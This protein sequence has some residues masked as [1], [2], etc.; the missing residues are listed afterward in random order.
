M[1][2]QPASGR[3]QESG[4]AVTA[5]IS[6]V[7]VVN[8]RALRA[9]DALA[10]EVGLTSARWQVLGV[11]AHGPSTVADIAREREL[12]RQSVQRTVER[13]R[14]E[15]LVRTEPNPDDRRAPLISLTPQAS[16]ALRALAPKQA[17]WANDLAAEL[18]LEE[19]R[20]ALKVLAVL[21]ERLDDQP[22]QS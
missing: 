10:A 21:K 16:Q 8:G 4:D 11:L 3:R 2:A 22:L 20:T 1:A 5:L 13:L 18:T 14:T 17:R 6:E 9:G 7:F 12:R 15:G 19:L